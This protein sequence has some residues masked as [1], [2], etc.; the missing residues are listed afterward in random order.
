[1]TVEPHQKF[2]RDFE[3]TTKELI[4]IPIVDFVKVGKQCRHVGFI[5]LI[6][7]K[8]LTLKKNL[9][10]IWCKNLHPK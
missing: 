1:M 10:E 9:Y 2:L 6:H 8:R 7:V 3:F 4:E 5:P